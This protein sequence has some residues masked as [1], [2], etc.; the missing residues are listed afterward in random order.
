MRLMLVWLVCNAVF[1]LNAF[2]HEDG[3]S[4][5]LSPWYLFTGKCLD[6]HKHVHLEFGSYIQTHEDHM[7]GMEAWTNGAICLGLSGNEQGGHY[8]MSL[9]SGKHI[10]RDCWTSLPMPHDMIA[11]V[12]QLAKEQGMP[13]SLTFAD[14]FGFEILDDHGDVDD[15]HNSNYT[16]D[17][18]SHASSDASDDYSYEMESTSDDDNDGGDDDSDH[19]GDAVAAQPLPGLNTGVDDPESDDDEATMMK[20][21]MKA[22]TMEMMW[23]DTT[24]AMATTTTSTMSGTWGNAMRAIQARKMATTMRNKSLRS[25]FPT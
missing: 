24:K 5:N 10:L 3:V 23:M 16:P 9:P 11:R 17:N 6:Y 13:K 7:N 12:N 25:T 21:M 14:R 22:K 1:G 8:F 18:D 2:P 4:D 20:V 19:G 15:N